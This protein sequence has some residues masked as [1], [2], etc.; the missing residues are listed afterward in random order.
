MRRSWPDLS[1]H[2]AEDDDLVAG[3]D[4]TDA[5]HPEH[6]AFLRRADLFQRGA[7]VVGDGGDE[8][9]FLAGLPGSA[10]ATKKPPAAERAK[11]PETV[12]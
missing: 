3:A 7:V 12:V 2:L 8:V 11:V 5:A 10:C 9:A 1:Q 4:R 6:D